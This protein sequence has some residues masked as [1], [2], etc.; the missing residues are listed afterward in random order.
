M[1]ALW[2]HQNL[3]VINE[4]MLREM[5]R[6]PDFH[7]RAAATRVLCYWRDSVKEPLALLHQQINDEHPRVRLEAIRALS[8][9]HE[10]EALNI[11]LELLTHPDDR[12]LQFVFNETLNTLERRL[13][14]GA[15]LDRKN[16]ALSLLKMLD[17]NQ[18]SAERKPALIETITRHGSAQEL[19]VI[20]DRAA[21]AGTYSPALRKQVLGWL[22]EA[23]VMR[24]VQPQ[25][26]ADAVQKLLAETANDAGLQAEAIRLATAW[27][28]VNAA[29]ELR[30]IAQDNVP[31]QTS[32]PFCRARRPSGA[33]RPGEYPNASGFDG[34]STCRSDS[35]PGSRGACQE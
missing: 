5:L 30:R 19:K 34:S 18:V 24:R 10:E 11:A 25:V 14:G 13:G 6:S 27:K 9:F 12:Y 31:G 29:G 15:R 2:L 23:A 33:R 21:Q 17:K 20:W 4:D 26:T 8:F 35:F 22:A 3:N 28:V 16:I 7:A 1:E 32:G